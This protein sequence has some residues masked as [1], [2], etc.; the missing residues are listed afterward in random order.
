MSLARACSSCD[1]VSLC[2]QTWESSSLLS[3]SVR[4]LIAG[5]LSSCREDAQISVIETCLL[6]EDDGLKQGLSQKL[7]WFCL[8][9]RLCS[10]CIQHSHLHRVVSEISWTRDDSPSCSGKALIIGE[11]TSSLAGKVPICLEPKTG[12]AP[13]AVWLLPVPET[14]SFYSPHSHL[15]RLVSEGSRN[16]DGSLR[17]SGLI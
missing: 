12:S 17:C 3:L 6:A 1:S 13:E 10:F 11:D 16:Q 8:S 2:Q 15:C 7:C 9:Q 14:I 5:K 4:V